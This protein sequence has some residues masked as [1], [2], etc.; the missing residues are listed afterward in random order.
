[1]LKLAPM[2][3]MALLRTMYHK[4]ACQAEVAGGLKL[5]EDTFALRGLPESD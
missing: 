3:A 5:P 2:H 1:M 4:G